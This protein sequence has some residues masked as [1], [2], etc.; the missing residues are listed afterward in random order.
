M[1]ISTMIELAGL[2]AEGRE[3]LRADFDDFPIPEGET[4][5]EAALRKMTMTTALGSREGTDMFADFVEKNSLPEGETPAGDPLPRTKKF[6]ADL[7]GE[8]LHLDHTA[9]EA[10]GARE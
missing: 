3:A 10:V 9:A 6:L 2:T 5:D 7:I 8:L 1:K 4:A